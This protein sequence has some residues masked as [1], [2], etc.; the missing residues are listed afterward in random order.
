MVVVFEEVGFHGCI[1]LAG[2]IDGVGGAGPNL[3]LRGLSLAA[4]MFQPKL[5]PFFHGR[6]GDRQEL[7]AA[8]VGH[9][10]VCQAVHVQDGDWL[11]GLAGLVELGGG[12]GCDGSKDIGHLAGQAVRE[13]AAVGVTGGVDALAIQDEILL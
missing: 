8:I 4:V 2:V 12:D 10:W 11:G 13:H 7:A 5:Q 3:L 1:E 6:E 9:D